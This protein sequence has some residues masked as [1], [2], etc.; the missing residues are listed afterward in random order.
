MAAAL[1]KDSSAARKERLG[2]F[3]G[4][5]GKTACV[6]PLPRKSQSISSSF[7]LFFSHGEFLAAA[8]I[9]ET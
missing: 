4:E 8:D 3:S 5:M 6:H 1:Y 7:G 9:R 2:S